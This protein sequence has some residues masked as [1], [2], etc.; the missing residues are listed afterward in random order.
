MVA[1]YSVTPGDLEAA[2]TQPLQHQDKL[3]ISRN[4]YPESA[5]L[6]DCWTHEPVLQLS[7]L[8]K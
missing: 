7:T 2:A 1:F 3:T 4:V 8:V 6:T 5:L